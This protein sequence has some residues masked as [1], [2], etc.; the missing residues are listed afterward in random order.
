MVKVYTKSPLMFEQQL[1]QL[2]GRGLIIEI[3]GLPGVT[4]RHL[5]HSCYLVLVT[6]D[7]YRKTRTARINDSP[8][9]ASKVSGYRPNSSQGAIPAH[10]VVQ[11]D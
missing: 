4:T 10:L 5:C 2:K 9:N 11:R 8:L 1:Q 7:G 3:M 6:N